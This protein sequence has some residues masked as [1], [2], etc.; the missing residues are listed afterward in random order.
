MQIYLPIAEIAV[1]VETIA[2]LGGLVGIISGVFGI[3]GGFLTTPFLI[4]LGIPPAVAVGTQSS[5]LVASSS[6]AVIGHW[7][8][9]NIDL[10]M[11]SI[12]LIGGA[13][14]TFIGILIFK[15][16]QYLGQVDLAISVLY[17]L[18]LCG[19]GGMML[20]ESATTLIRAKRQKLT[21]DDSNISSGNLNQKSR[22]QI[23]R[24][25]L[26]YKMNF[27]ES[28]LY[29]S[30]ILPLGLGFLGGLMVSVMG[31]GAGFLLVPAMIYFLRMPPLLVT[32]TSLI[33]IAV[34]SALACV[35]HAVTNQTVDLILAAV[36]I[37]G[38][39]IGAQIGVRLSRYIRGATARFILASIIMVVGLKLAA[40]LLIPPL[41]L[42]T[43]VV[44]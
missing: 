16:L 34:T 6:T 25:N 42:Y 30:M 5:Q 21:Q 43:I 44:Q 28:R 31:I 14:G 13:F 8:K 18:F 17:V 23:W 40:E 11:A 37:G 39:V 38:S 1:S 3:G 2:L 10:K 22:T 41:N 24:D 26:P 35:L 29:I 9:Q 12:L 32:G 7:R 19:I 33:Q 36:L 27:P 20:S 15:F 4:F